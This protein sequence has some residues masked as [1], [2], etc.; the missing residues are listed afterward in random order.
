MNINH[1]SLDRTRHAHGTID[2]M[3]LTEEENYNPN[4]II[5]MQHAFAILNTQQLNADALK[6]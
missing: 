2:I 1:Y 5:D 3:I 4:M 6:M